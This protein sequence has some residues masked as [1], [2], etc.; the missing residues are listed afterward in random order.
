MSFRANAMCEHLFDASHTPECEPSTNVGATHER[1]RNPEKQK[2]KF[3]KKNFHIFKTGLSRISIKILT[4][5]K[6]IFSKNFPKIS[7]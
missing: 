6:G 1:G 2:V 4:M 3:S 5:T 7:I